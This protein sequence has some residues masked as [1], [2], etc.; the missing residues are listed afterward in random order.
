M[1]MT[2]ALSCWSAVAKLLGLRVHLGT[3]F[4]H[5]RD[6]LGH[7]LPGRPS[8]SPCC[9]PAPRPKELYG[10]HGARKD[11]GSVGAAEG[12]IANRSSG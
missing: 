9:S 5:H 2:A 6:A 7:R 1:D 4:I 8:P 3:V 10:K 12:G 11:F